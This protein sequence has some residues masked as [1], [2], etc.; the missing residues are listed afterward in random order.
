MSQIYSTEKV[1]RLPRWARGLITSLE[2]EIK[3]LQDTLAATMGDASNILTNPYFDLQKERG[4]YLP[5]HTTVRYFTP[6]GR[7]DV[8]IG[9]EGLVV[10]GDNPIAVFPRASNVVNIKGDTL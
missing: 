3:H 9:A 2:G 7:F 1:A 8:T 4:R 5:N 10:Y 6:H